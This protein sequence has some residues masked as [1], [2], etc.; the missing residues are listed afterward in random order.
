[1]SHVTMW[2]S[3]GWGE[4]WENGGCVRFVCVCALVCVCGHGMIEDDEMRDDE[5]E[6]DGRLVVLVLRA[7][8]RFDVL[9]LRRCSVDACVVIAFDVFR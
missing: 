6:R 7:G 2:A 3:F 9:V 1:M 8:V 5:R 4:L